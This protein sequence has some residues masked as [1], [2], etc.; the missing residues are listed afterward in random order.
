MSFDQSKFNTHHHFITQVQFSKLVGLMSGVADVANA[1]FVMI[2]YPSNGIIKRET[3]AYLV[4][5][6]ALASNIGGG[7]GL[8]LGISMFSLLDYV[9]QIILNRINIP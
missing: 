5:G 4:D 9:T 2:R 7:L 6:I 1:K 3:K 8:A